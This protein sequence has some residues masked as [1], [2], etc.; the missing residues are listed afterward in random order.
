MKPTN[1][2]RYYVYAY[3]RE[4][5]SANG[6][7]YSPYYIGKGSGNR[8]FSSQ[9]KPVNK[10]KDKSLIVYVQEC[11]T[12]QEAF[13]LEHYCIAIYGRIDLGTGCLRNKSNGGEGASGVIK[14]ESTRQ[15]ISRA[16]KGKVVTMETRKKIGEASK[17]RKL[18]LATRKKMSESRKG[19]GNAFWGQKHS[20]EFIAKRSQNSAIYEYELVGPDGAIYTTHSLTLFAKE[21]GL[22]QG[23]LS[24]VA[25]GKRKEHQ[26]WKV[27]IIKSLK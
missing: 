4:T 27:C 10:P 5:A 12:E 20:E 2:R 14:S 3:L 22:R 26:G 1:S 9:G 16:H 18:S 23:C 21:H 11:L 8:I 19:E 15:K 7:K 17:G 24:L 6:V 25:H 13:A